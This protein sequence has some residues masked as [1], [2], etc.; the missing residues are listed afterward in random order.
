MLFSYKAK[1]KDGIIVTEVMESPDRF[2][3][4]REL[5]SHG[6]TVFSVREKKENPLDIDKLFQRFFG[7][8][9]AQEQITF[10]KNLSGMLR[11]GLSLSRAI[12]VL[13][14]QPRIKNSILF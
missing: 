13:Q 3:L 14:K 10:T 4:A 1:T 11:A 12:S 8:V 5:K 7:K 2:S 9:K 6:C